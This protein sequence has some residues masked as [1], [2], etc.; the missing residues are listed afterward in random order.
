LR[1][2]ALVH[3]G[4]LLQKWLESS[5]KRGLSDGTQNRAS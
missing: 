1:K 3:V 5:G 2:G 4:R